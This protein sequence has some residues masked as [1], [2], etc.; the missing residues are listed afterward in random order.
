MLRHVQNVLVQILKFEYPSDQ[1]LSK[2]YKEHRQLGARDRTIISDTVYCVIRELMR[3]KA[4]IKHISGADD[5]PLERKLAI[6]AWAGDFI[7]LEKKLSASE[8]DWLNSTRQFNEKEISFPERYSMPE[9]IIHGVEPLVGASH[10]EAFA[11][12]ML[13][14][15]PLDLRVNTLKGKREQVQ[16]NLLANGIHTEFT[17]YAP[18]GLRLLEKVS[19]L[20]QP[21]YQQGIIEIQDEGSQLLAHLV[22]AKRNEVIIDYCAGAGGKTLALGACMRNTG[23]LYAWDVSAHRL[24]ALKPR[25]QRSGLS[26]VYTA[27][28]T[29]N[30]DE[31]IKRLYG[32]ADRV[33]VDAPCS[34]LGTLRRNPELKWRVTKTDID[35]LTQVQMAILANASQLVKVGGLLIYATCSVI[36]EENEI[37][38]KQ[39]TQDYARFKPVDVSK[40]L[41]MQKFNGNASLVQNGYLRLWPHLHQT[42]G[43]FAAVWQR[44]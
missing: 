29:N 34:G 30:Q 28:I 8:L 18:H 7:W 33:L 11:Q 19:L 20:Q 10:I 31:R 9:W 12:S 14:T 16:I 25:L 41:D 2:Y 40:L 4:I 17:P 39:F 27:A 26:N 22:G 3:F 24:D 44:C 35:A 15:A 21:L 37:I 32:K 43:F 36:Q 23:R 6:L 42:D 1:F 13:H 5:A 38:T